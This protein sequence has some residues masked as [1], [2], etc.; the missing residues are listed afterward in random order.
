[1]QAN[2]VQWELGCYYHLYNRG[3]N[4]TSIFYDDADYLD[5][6]RR[7]KKYTNL[8]QVTVIAYC[9][10]PNHY[11]ILVR[12]DGDHKAGLVVQHICNGYTQAFN[13]RHQRDGTLFQGRFQRLLV[14]KEEYLRHLCRYIHINPVKDGFAIQPDLWTYSNYRDWVGLRAGTLVDH[15]FIVEHFGSPA[16][17]IKVVEGWPLRKQMPKSLL[18]HLVKL[19]HEE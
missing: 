7:L 9:L 16:A 15:A 10:M 3:A 1:M 14:D 13:C 8:H 5:F 12:Q 4:R 18:E 11:H 2:E 6:L 17:Y 19:E